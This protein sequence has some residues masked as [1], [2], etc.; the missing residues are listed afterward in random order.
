MLCTVHICTMKKLSKKK[1]ALRRKRISEGLK[2]H[3]KNLKRYEATK[4]KRKAAVKAKETKFKK[5]MIGC[6]EVFDGAEYAF[7][8]K[9]QHVAAL[10]LQERLNQF[11][12]HKYIIKVLVWLGI[13]STTSSVEVVS[14]NGVDSDLT[15]LIFESHVTEDPF[16]TNYYAAI[17]LYVEENAPLG[18]R[19]YDSADIQLRYM[20]V[21]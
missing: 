9:G 12:D 19:K 1:E 17:R 14:G 13:R 5:R 2:R 11:P 21:C 10:A 6:Q 15:E 4:K 16:W 7:F 18:G 20:Q 3:Y 8:D